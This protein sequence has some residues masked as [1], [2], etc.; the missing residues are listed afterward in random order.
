MLTPSFASSK[1]AIL[2]TD[3]IQ[4]TDR[5]P[6]TDLGVAAKSLRDIG[7]H[8]Y[9]FGIG[10]ALDPVALST[11]ASYKQENV[12]RASNF[13]DLA[14]PAKSILASVCPSECLV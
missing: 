1:V 11:I 3:G 8:V 10:K 13:S 12:F 14:G 5:G 9:S 6:Y 7:V 4:T 2:I